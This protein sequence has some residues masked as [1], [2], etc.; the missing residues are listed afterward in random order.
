MTAFGPHF[1]K[2][3]GGKGPSKMFQKKVKMFPQNGQV[4]RDL[5]V[6]KANMTN[7]IQKKDLR[8]TS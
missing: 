1:E 7:V 4:A 6:K 5:C 2:H 8:G 3:L